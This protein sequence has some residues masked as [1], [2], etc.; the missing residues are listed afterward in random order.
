MKKSFF[1]LAAVAIFWLPIM[2][3]GHHH[4]GNSN[5]PNGAYCPPDSELRYATMDNGR[6]IVLFPDGTWEF[7]PMQPPPRPVYTSDFWGN[8]LIVKQQ[9]KEIARI[10]VDYSTRYD[11][12][13]RSYMGDLS[14]GNAPFTFDGAKDE[15]K[16]AG[17][18]V[19]GKAHSMSDAKSVAA[20]YFTNELFQGLHSQFWGNQMIIYRNG[21]EIDRVRVSH[22]TKYDRGHGA[23]NAGV[24]IGTANYKFDG[25]TKQV[26]FLGLK[27]VGKAFN[28]TGAKHVA[29]FH[30]LQ[31][32]YLNGGH[33]MVVK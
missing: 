24:T 6:R 18:R 29:A 30:Y 7:A 16:F 26:R 4:H 20:Y 23:Y 15:V 19:I 3:Q 17:V 13:S 28:V 8:R 22:N 33:W 14:I 9:G 10:P 21:K 12:K 1:L 25:H 2:A 11:R 5:H 31:E 27:L 32:H